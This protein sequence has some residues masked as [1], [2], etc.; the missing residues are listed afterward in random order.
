M[1]NTQQIRVCLL[2]SVSNRFLTQTVKNGFKR[3]NPINFKED[4]PSPV[5][6]DWC[7]KIINKDLTQITKTHQFILLYSSEQTSFIHLL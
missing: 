3:K 2:S 4:V 7:S 6:I 5:A 1:L